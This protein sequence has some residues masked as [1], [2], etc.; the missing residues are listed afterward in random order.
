MSYYDCYEPEQPTKEEFEEMDGA[1]STETEYLPENIKIEFNTEN[2]ANGIISQVR[3]EVKKNLYQEVV[4]QIKTELLQEMRETI[5]QNANDIVKEIIVEFINTEKVKTGNNFWGDEEVKEYSMIEYAKKCIAD[6]IKDKKMRVV[7]GV[8]I[9]NS[10]YNGSGS[11]VTTKEISFEDYIKAELGIG[12]EAKAYFD[13]QIASVRKQ[14]NSD[15]KNAFDES[16]KSML[17]EAVL[18]VLM[19]NDTYKK[20]ESNISCIATRG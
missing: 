5:K 10:R 14:I 3:Q 1:N 4:S 12:N 16:T 2:F 17:S 7:T 11:K 13:E 6:C 19:A 8:K 20:I 9:D 18:N 15:I